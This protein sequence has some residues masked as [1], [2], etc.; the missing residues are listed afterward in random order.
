MQTAALDDVFA[1]LSDPTRR[2]FVA[3]LGN[4]PRS[5]S[6]LAAG[7]DISLP[8]VS[9]HIKVLEKAGLIEREKRGRTHFVALAPKALDDAMAFLTRTRAMWESNLDALERF[10]AMEAE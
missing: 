4:G 5:I 2:Q 9:R 1:A 8:A 6:D 10:L 3:E 7:V